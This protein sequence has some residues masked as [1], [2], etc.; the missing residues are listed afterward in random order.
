MYSKDGLCRCFTALVVSMVHEL[1]LECQK[2]L[3]TQ[4]LYQQ[5]PVRLMLAVMLCVASHC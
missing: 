2:K 1:A 3:L 5:L 4:A